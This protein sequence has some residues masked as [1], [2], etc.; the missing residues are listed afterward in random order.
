MTSR[1]GRLLAK[2]KVGSEFRVRHPIQNG[3]QL[4]ERLWEDRSHLR[5][6]FPAGARA[7]GFWSVSTPEVSSIDDRHPRVQ[8]RPL[9]LM[10]AVRGS[11]GTKSGDVRCRDRYEYSLD[12]CMGSVHRHED[13]ERTGRTMRE[14]RAAASRSPSLRRAQRRTR[15]QCPR[16]ATLRAR[17]RTGW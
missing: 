3:V 4:Y 17:T 5:V 13:N 7:H 2:S 16:I 11:C 15:M 12:I 1:E 9:D 10:M 14:P 8:T 6:A